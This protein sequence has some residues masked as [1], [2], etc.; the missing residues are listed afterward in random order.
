M[1]VSIEPAWQRRLFPHSTPAAACP[2]G[3]CLARREP[4]VQ[5]CLMLSSVVTDGLDDLLVQYFK[6]RFNIGVNDIVRCCPILAICW[7]FDAPVQQ[8]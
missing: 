4:G 8:V 1:Q 3:R 2:D 5:A 6:L 7:S